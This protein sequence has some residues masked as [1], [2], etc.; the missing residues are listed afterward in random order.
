VFRPLFLVTLD[1]KKGDQKIHNEAEGLTPFS[2]NGA[3]PFFSGA[4]P[5]DALFSL[6][7]HGFS[8]DVLHPVQHQRWR[9]VCRESRRRGLAAD[10]RKHGG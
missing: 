7:E 2:C 5:G 4:S 8:A 3:A 10:V 9:S 6:S 1:A